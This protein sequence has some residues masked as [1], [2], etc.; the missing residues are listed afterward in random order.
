MITTLTSAEENHVF[1]FTFPCKMITCNVHSSL[2]A[3]GLMAAMTEKLTELGIG[4]NPVSAFFHDHLFVPVGRE[5]EAVA[6]LEELAEEAKRN[7]G[8]DA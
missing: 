7:H 2:E 1:D 3:V 5:H 4:S 8:D 6:A